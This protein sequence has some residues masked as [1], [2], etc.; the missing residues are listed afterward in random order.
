MALRRRLLWTHGFYMGVLCIAGVYLFLSQWSNAR[1]NKQQRENL[2]VVHAVMQLK[3]DAAKYRLIQKR[4]NSGDTTLT[5]SLDDIKIKIEKD[6][7]LVAQMTHQPSVK[8]DWMSYL[9]TPSPANEEVYRH[10]SEDLLSR[11][12]KL[13]PEIQVQSSSEFT[14]KELAT[15][16]LPHLEA[17]IQEALLVGAPLVTQKTLSVFERI[18]LGR[19]SAVLRYLTQEQVKIKTGASAVQDSMEPVIGFIALLKNLS[20]NEKVQISSAQFFNLGERS[21]D[22][23][24]K[25]SRLATL[26]LGRLMEIRSSVRSNI[27]WSFISL[28]FLMTLSFGVGIFFQ[29]KQTPA[30]PTEATPIATTQ[31]HSALIHE[32]LAE[33]S[34]RGSSL[35]QMASN[36]VR[37]EQSSR[38][39]QNALNE[40]DEKLS[41]VMELLKGN[42]ESNYQVVREVRDVYERFDSIF[43]TNA[44]MNT[45]VQ[46]LQEV[47]FQ[48]KLFS[49]NAA[50]EGVKSEESSRSLSVLSEEIGRLGHL[51]GTLADQLKE[52]LQKN[53]SKMKGAL[54]PLKENLIVLIRKN[55]DSLKT[56]TQTIERSLIS[57]ETLEKGLSTLQQDLE[58][59]SSSLAQEPEALKRVSDWA[60]QVGA[61]APKV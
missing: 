28:F 56:A 46:Q 11:V 35:S 27:P 42:H 43:K 40:D 51:G 48:L 18:Q 52:L 8:K 37:I 20:E 29:W 10:L 60:N 47:L 38:N 9:S 15:E 2:D 55:E 57:R 45:K 23:I 36:A 41:Q 58:E 13:Y 53:Q 54:L 5:A 32:I 26:E 34:Q 61:A 16:I 12:S 30:L 24:S 44:E 21:L 33:L 19:M 25:A 50:I 6:A 4:I 3:I 7:D 17:R 22:I 49:F 31:V 14:V 39:L 59:T 1:I